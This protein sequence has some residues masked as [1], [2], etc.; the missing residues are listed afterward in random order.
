D[1]DGAGGYFTSQRN[2]AEERIQIKKFFDDA[3][4]AMDKNDLKIVRAS[5]KQLIS[6][7]L[8]VFSYP[9]IENNHLRTLV[10]NLS[11][12]ELF[13]LF[14]V[15]IS[16][17]TAFVPQEQSL[18]LTFFKEMEQRDFYHPLHFFW[19]NKLE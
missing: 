10:Y 1:S 3:I 13:A 17:P 5:L 19:I 7:L 11:S 9:D 8:H 15:H 14:Y 16:N 6:V 2:D 12:E 18:L 4:G